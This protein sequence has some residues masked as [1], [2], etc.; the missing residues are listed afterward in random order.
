VADLEQIVLHVD[1]AAVNTVTIESHRQRI[2]LLLIAVGTA[3]SIIGGLVQN[4]ESGSS[5][6]S[7]IG[8]PLIVAGIIKL[9]HNSRHPDV[10][11]KRPSPSIP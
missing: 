1:R 11:Y 2:G 8:V 7:A 4:I 3:S 9:H 5:I 6:G 10:V